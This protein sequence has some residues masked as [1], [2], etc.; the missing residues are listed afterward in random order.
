MKRGIIELIT[1]IIFLAGLTFK[2]AHYPGIITCTWSWPR[3][4]SIT[5]SFF[6]RVIKRPFVFINL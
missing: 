1:G 4:N 6:Q 3:V 2:F 5:R